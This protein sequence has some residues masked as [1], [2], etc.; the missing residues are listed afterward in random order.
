MDYITLEDFLRLCVD[1]TGLTLVVY[2]VSLRRIVY[3]G[4]ADETDPQYLGRV[5]H[6]FDIPDEIGALTVNI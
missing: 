3:K 2:D 5:V 6:S 4:W 1:D